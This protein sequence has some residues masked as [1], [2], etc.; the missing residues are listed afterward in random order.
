[1]WKSTRRYGNGDAIVCYN[2]NFKSQIISDNFRFYSIASVIGR[3]RS[4][5]N[6]QRKVKENV[7]LSNGVCVCIQIFSFALPLN[8]N[9][10]MKIY[11]RCVDSIETMNL[12]EMKNDEA[13]ML[14]FV[15]RVF[16]IRLTVSTHHCRIMAAR[17]R[18]SVCLCVFQRKTRN[19]SVELMADC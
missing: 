14:S 8:G 2:F 16:F 19:S 17:E 9:F 3:R 18:G 12:A 15:L 13:K 4:Q 7:F 1:M 5:Q 11:D 6:S 10:T